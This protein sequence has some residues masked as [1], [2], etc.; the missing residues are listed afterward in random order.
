[1]TALLLVGVESS[2]FFGGGY[3]HYFINITF[4]STLLFSWKKTCFY[5]RLEFLSIISS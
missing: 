3:K 5:C 1:M 2:S 4:K